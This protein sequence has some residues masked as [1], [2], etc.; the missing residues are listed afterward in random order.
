MPRLT[1]R[2][3]RF[4]GL[5]SSTAAVTSARN[6][7]DGSQRHRSCLHRLALPQRFSVA[8]FLVH[9]AIPLS[10]SVLTSTLPHRAASNRAVPAAVLQLTSRP[11]SSSNFTTALR[12]QNA[13]GHLT[14]AVTGGGDRIHRV[15]CRPLHWDGRIARRSEVFYWAATVRPDG[16]I[17]RIGLGELCHG[18]EGEKTNKFASFGP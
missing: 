1:T 2:Q 14:G 7:T 17:L 11:E 4:T 5:R 15:E 3:T 10:E 6:F 9:R 13:A 16:R 12:V 8:A 18:T